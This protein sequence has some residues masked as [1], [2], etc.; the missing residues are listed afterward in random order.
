MAGDKSGPSFWRA[1]TRQDRCKECHWRDIQARRAWGC[2]AKVCR[3]AVR[4]PSR[5]RSSTDTAGWH[6]RTL[7]HGLHLRT[8][9]LLAMHRDQQQVF[10]V[11]RPGVLAGITEHRAD[12]VIA[13]RNQGT[14]V[15]TS[16]GRECPRSGCRESWVEV[17]PSRSSDSSGQGSAGLRKAHRE[18]HQYDTG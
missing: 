10:D 11:F 12:G 7:S 2:A 8:T 3:G 15:L 9:R 4:R 6:G 5:F 1:L 13:E 17:K 16:W 14:P 18:W